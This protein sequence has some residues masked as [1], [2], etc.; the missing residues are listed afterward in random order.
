[1]IIAFLTKIV[2]KKYKKI[3]KTVPFPS[4]IRILAV[5]FSKYRFRRKIL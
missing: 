2:K 5:F 3:I 4:K 1:M